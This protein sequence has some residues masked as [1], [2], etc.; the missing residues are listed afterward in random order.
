[1]DQSS[2]RPTTDTWNTPKKAGKTRGE[3]RIH[4]QTH[5]TRKNC[6]KIPLQI[7]ITS[8]FSSCLSPYSTP[9]TRA[10]IFPDLI[11]L[12]FL[13]ERVS[14]PFE[15]GVSIE[16]YNVSGFLPVS[17]PRLSL[18]LPPWCRPR[19]LPEG[20]LSLFLY[21][22]SFFL[23]LLCLIWS[24]LISYVSRKVRIHIEKPLR[25]GN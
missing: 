4:H 14:P 16:I 22:F 20:R 6:T 18:L 9:Q 23:D 3:I 2:P 11:P 25:E 17:N 8:F 24:G 5:R 7:Q 15:N 10:Y 21:I 1:M 12:P 19:G 13:K